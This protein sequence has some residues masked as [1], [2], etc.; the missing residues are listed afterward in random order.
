MT[1]GAEF[2]HRQCH[3]C[4]GSNHTLG[5]QYLNIDEFRLPTRF[6]RIIAGIDIWATDIDRASTYVT[7]STLTQTIME[8]GIITECSCT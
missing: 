6:D 8:G 4:D 5:Q 7:S 1:I 3:F 2:V